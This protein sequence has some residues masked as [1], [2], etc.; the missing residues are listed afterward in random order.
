[1]SF[2][3]E[4]ALNII[5]ALFVIA[6]LKAVVEDLLKD[7]QFYTC[8]ISEFMVNYQGGFVRRGLLGE[9]IFHTV[10]RLGL[11]LQWTVKIFS[12]ACFAV[13]CSFFVVMFRRKGYSLLM[14]PLCFFL[15]G[16]VMSSFEIYCGYNSPPDWI[17]KDYMMIGIFIVSVFIFLKEKLSYFVKILLISILSVFVI[18][19]HEV[20]AFI[21]IPVFFLLFFTCGC[22]VG[23]CSTAKRIMLA[24]LAVA[25]ALAALVAVVHFRGY[26]GISEIIWN[27]WFAQTGEHYSDIPE[28]TITA[29]GSL[30]WDESMVLRGHF[31]RNFIKVDFGLLSTFYWLIAFPLIYWIATTALLVFRNNETTFSAADRRRLSATLI[32]QFLCLTPFFTVLSVDYIRLV[33]Y[34]VASAF[35]VFLLVPSAQLNRLFPAWYYRL[36][37]RINNRIDMVLPHSRSVMAIVMLTIGISYYSFNMSTV[38]MSSA[39]WR[40]M[41][42]MTSIVDF[43]IEVSGLH[44]AIF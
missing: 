16:L 27:S 15:G 31:F 18:L 6:L 29:V 36:I 5:F 3:K 39:W 26:A 21:F 8:N 10:N 32:F 34:V 40:I 43:M 42:F 24:A 30:E 33:F 9:I 37:D 2:S 22:G 28:G 11:D 12:L 14:L 17:R 19:S 23:S 13:V 41:E 35:A 38:V 44:E 1:M 4:K 20:Y 7:Y 25:P